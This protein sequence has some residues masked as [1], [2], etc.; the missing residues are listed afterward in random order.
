MS[1]KGGKR[2]LATPVSERLKHRLGVDSVSYAS[3][4]STQG[5]EP[6]VDLQE[7]RG[8][9]PNGIARAVTWGGLVLLTARLPAEMLGAA[10]IIQ[11][12]LFLV[13]LLAVFGGLAW[14]ERSE[15]K[16]RR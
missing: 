14:Q 7:G 12:A 10:P 13:G 9:K 3:L 6:M 5:G 2:T 1:Q 8:P 4:S 16:A 15:R 11:D